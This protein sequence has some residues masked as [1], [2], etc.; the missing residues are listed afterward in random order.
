M[1][2]VI[3]DI[4]MIN[5]LRKQILFTPWGLKQRGIIWK[6]LG[7]CFGYTDVQYKTP[8]IFCQSLGCNT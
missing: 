6:L 2:G 8:L 7:F 4:T 5:Y 1:M 3:Y